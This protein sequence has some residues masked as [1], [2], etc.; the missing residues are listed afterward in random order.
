MGVLVSA[1]QRRV[2][3]A[4]IGAI[5]VLLQGLEPD[6][7]A[8]STNL[9]DRTAAWPY[10][11][12]TGP[13]LTHGQSLLARCLSPKLLSENSLPPVMSNVT[14]PVEIIPGHRDHRSGLGD[15]VIAIGTEH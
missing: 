12:L 6:S 10:D 13:D 11:L 14:P 1:V 9:G 8:V 5:F 4:F 7:S 15:K 3:L 2:P